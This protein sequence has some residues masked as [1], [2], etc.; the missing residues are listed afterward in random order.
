MLQQHPCTAHQKTI[1]ESI[2]RNA[3]H[4]HF[5]FSPFVEKNREK[6]WLQHLDGIHINWF[7]Q[8]NHAFEIY[9]FSFSFDRTHTFECKANCF[10]SVATRIATTSVSLTAGKKL[11]ATS[12][13]RR[14]RSRKM[15]C[16]SNWI[17]LFS[18]YCLVLTA[19]SSSVRP[20]NRFDSIRTIIA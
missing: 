15:L 2:I 7:A 10:S 14:R 17:V 19:V 4:F 11:G 20:Q 1:H 13:K 18:H 5:Q 3:I 12:R 6:N 8:M 16:K 9:Y